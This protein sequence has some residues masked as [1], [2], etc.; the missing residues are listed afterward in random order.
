MFRKV[1]RP[2]KW[3]LSLLVGVPLLGYA[4]QHV[5]ASVPPHTAGIGIVMCLPLFGI[6]LLFYMFARWH[7]GFHR[8]MTGRS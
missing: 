7:R 2:A 5:L 8:R 1:S 3:V 6:C 4:C